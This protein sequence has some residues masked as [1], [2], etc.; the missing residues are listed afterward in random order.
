MPPKGAWTPSL[1]VSTVLTTIQAL[2]S[3]PNPE[4]GLMS[5]IVCTFIYYNFLI[6]FNIFI[7]YIYYIFI[8]FT[9]YLYLFVHLDI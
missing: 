7:Y 8:I 4:D 1:N 2:L 3:E 9:L 6:C 5:D